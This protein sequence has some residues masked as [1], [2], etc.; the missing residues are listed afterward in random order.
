M[1]FAKPK[2]IRDEKLLGHF[3]TVTYPLYYLLQFACIIPSRRLATEIISVSA[4]P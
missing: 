4:C 1:L 3:L 2:D